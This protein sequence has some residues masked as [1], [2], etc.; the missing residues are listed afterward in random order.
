MNE[1]SL[2]YVAQCVESEGF[3]YAMIHYSNYDQVK[4]EKFHELK[5]KFEDAR[6]E[7]AEYLGC[8]DEI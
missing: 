1:K 5:K 7:L 4:D 2:A 6:T 3:D 8:E